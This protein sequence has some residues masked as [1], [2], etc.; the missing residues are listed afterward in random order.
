MLKVLIFS[1]FTLIKWTGLLKLNYIS[2]AKLNKPDCKKL[3]NV[4]FS[5]QST[6][7]LNKSIFNLV[8]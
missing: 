3:V 7:L 5:E 1:T 4:K 8:L 6:L 2:D